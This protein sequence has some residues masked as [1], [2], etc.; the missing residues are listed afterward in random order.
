[1]LI[2]KH[3]IIGFLSAGSLFSTSLAYSSTS[4]PEAII[5][6]AE[7]ALRFS[8]IKNFLTDLQNN[9]EKNIMPVPG[10]YRIPKNQLEELISLALRQNLKVLILEENATDFLVALTLERR[11]PIVGL[12]LLDPDSLRAN[13]FDNLPHITETRLFE[14]TTNM[15]E[16]IGYGMAVR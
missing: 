9:C 7:E 14:S 3:W 8:A 1:M 12:V 15:R 11:G 2:S 10:K 5:A 6:P 13:D 16:T 4:N